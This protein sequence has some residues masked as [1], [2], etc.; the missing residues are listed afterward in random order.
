M[1]RKQA[2]SIFMETALCMGM[3][4][5]AFAQEA[6]G[7]SI[8]FSEEEILNKMKGGWVG[9]MAGVTWAA[10]TEF[11][12]FGKFFEID[13]DMTIIPDDLVPEWTPE[14]INDAFN[15]DDLYV[16]VTFLDCLKENGT[17][18]D[19]SVY[20]KY[21]GESQYRLWH[22]NRWGRD[23]VRAGIDAPWSGHY[24]N[25]L[26]A[27]DIDWQIE[28]D[29]IGMACLAMPEAAKDLAWKI[30]H[31]MNYGD[32]VYGGVFVSTMYAKAFTA[33][34][35]EE[36]IQAGM[37]AIPQD[38]QFW[39]TQ[40][41]VLECRENGMTWEE[42]REYVADNYSNPRCPNSL[43]NEDK[44]N[45]DAKINSAWITLGLV[46][47][48][49]DIEQSMYI[50]MRCGGDSDCNPASVGGILGCYYGYDAFE[51]KWTS[52]IDW[53]GMQFEYTDY[54]LNTAIEANMD[55]ARQVVEAY[56][57]SI[58]NGVWTIPASDTEGTIIL[59]QWPKELNEAPEFDYVVSTNGEG[60]TVYFEA[61]A[62]DADG[63][64]DYQW[65]FDDLSFA[66]GQSVS[67]TYREDGAY[68]VLCYVTDGIGNTSWRQ[69]DI[70]VHE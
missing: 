70:L 1:K 57:G 36:I 14:T 44:F 65:F 47:G 5:L 34:S 11:Y 60:R 63:I 32:G 66:N 50:S 7:E 53:D 42:A 67:H 68:T 59:E 2:M 43:Y 64:G 40:N 23:N 46:Y 28:C 51:E 56:G 8:T 61:K 54:T 35:I 38:S 20:G 48:E 41:A 26:H 19:W 12:D 4:Q 39:Q 33:T 18:T 3:P 45:I 17:Q 22:A 6:A 30:G 52:A 31:V 29:A 10:P 25:T 69:I 9:E 15:Q 21:F 49:G 16:D 55:A 24:S 27:D 62:T 58:E 13:P 37:N